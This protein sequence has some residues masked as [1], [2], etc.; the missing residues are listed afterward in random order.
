MKNLFLPRF[1]SLW[2]I[3]CL[4]LPSPAFALREIQTRNS[5]AEEEDLKQALR[6]RA[7]A[8][9]APPTA[10]AEEA[11]G[12]QEMS[13][14]R[15]LRSV[16]MG[17]MGVLASQ[18]PGDV[19][20]VK[21]PPFTPEV[22]TSSLDNYFRNLGRLSR[23]SWE[24]VN[25]PYAAASDRELQGAYEAIS[26]LGG[27][28]LGVSFQQ[29][30]SFAVHGNPS[31]YVILDINPV[32][33]EIFVPLFGH[34]FE[35]AGTRR[36]FLS[37]LL[38]V[39]LSQEEVTRLLEPTRR[40]GVELEGHLR[41]VLG[42]VMGRVPMEEKFRRFQE[43][44]LRILHDE[45]F[46]RLERSG[47]LRGLRELQG[48][49]ELEEG[50]RIPRRDIPQKA[51]ELFLDPREIL[52]VRRHDTSGIVDF[53]QFLSEHAQ[54]SWFGHRRGGWLSSEENYQTLRRQWIEGNFVGVTASLTDPEAL[55]GIGRWVQETGRDPF[56]ML[57]PSPM[58]G[59]G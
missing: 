24:Q 26:N 21:I 48:V 46:Q 1:L 28:M 54:A 39:D 32:V 2:L 19:G 41:S 44:P 52:R 36:E 27:T 9:T 33:T 6:G 49:T 5:G 4:A 22:L 30:F 37:F 34:L 3:L 14:R 58:W 17:A 55:A 18:I 8:G 42:E 43:G 16:G 53:V 56:S 12:K 15:W 25:L 23:G 40:E 35:R 29:N 51:L 31:T 13:R 50:V 45:I 20:R 11:Q 7:S 57:Y 59:N 38:G 47:R 10:G